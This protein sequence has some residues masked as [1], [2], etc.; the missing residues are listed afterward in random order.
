[1]GR[2]RGEPYKRRMLMIHDDVW[3]EMA[4]ECE[5]RSAEQHRRVGYSEMVN[6]ALREVFAPEEQERH[7]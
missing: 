3:E 7:E 6:S 1:M 4:K 5:R 2:T